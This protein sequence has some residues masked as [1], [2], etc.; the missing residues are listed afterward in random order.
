MKLERFQEAVDDCTQVIE[1][2][3]ENTK[4]LMCRATAYS[5]FGK[6][7]QSKVGRHFGNNS[8]KSVNTTKY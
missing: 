8:A 2:E 4:A 7:A 3:P 5:A 6:S 1:R